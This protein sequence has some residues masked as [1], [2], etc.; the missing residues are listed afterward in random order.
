MTVR[1]Y[2]EKISDKVIE[3]RLDENTKEREKN[4]I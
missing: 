4:K 2:R 3:K 1:A